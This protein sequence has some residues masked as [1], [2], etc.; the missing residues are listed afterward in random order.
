MANRASQF[1]GLKKGWD[2]IGFASSEPLPSLL[3]GC[4]FSS[5]RTQHSL[6]QDT[7]HST[8]QDTIRHTTRLTTGHPFP[9]LLEQIFG[10]HCE[11]GR[12][13]E[14]TTKNA[15]NRSLPVLGTKW[16]L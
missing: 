8:H 7:G 16:R 3:V 10:I 4:R 2:L 15:L 9:D 11:V 5:C 1:T 12:N 13:V 14:F 6:Q